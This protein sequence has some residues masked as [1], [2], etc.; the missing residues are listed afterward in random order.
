MDMD[1]K[2]LEDSAE[3]KHADLKDP[4]KKPVGSPTEVANPSEGTSPQEMTTTAS[5]VGESQSSKQ[6][7]NN[8]NDLASS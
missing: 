4:V 3:N 6:L 2:E 5:E 1:L 8:R 7:Q